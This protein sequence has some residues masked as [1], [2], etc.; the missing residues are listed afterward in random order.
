MFDIDKNI[1][2][3]RCTT[4]IIGKVQMLYFDITLN[5]SRCG[6]KTI[7]LRHPINDRFGIFILWHHTIDGNQSLNQAQQRGDKNDK[8]RIDGHKAPGGNAIDTDIIIDHT[9]RQGRQG[10]GRQAQQRHQ[11]SSFILHLSLFGI[12]PNPFQIG[13]AFGPGHPQPRN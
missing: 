10:N 3:N 6:F 4:L 9:H 11:L 2:E 1:V 7:H 5:F 8:G 12:L 13:S